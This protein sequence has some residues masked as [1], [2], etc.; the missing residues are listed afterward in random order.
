MRNFPDASPPGYGRVDA[1]GAI[2]NEVFHEA[3]VIPP[4]TPAAAAAL[5]NSK[6]ADAPVSY[7]FLW[8][9]PQHNV[10]QW[11]GV[12]QNA[13]LG[14]LGRNVGEVLGVF[15]RVD[16]P[17]KPGVTGY[18]SSVQVR[19]LRALEKL[20][21]GLWSPQWPA[22]LPPIDAALRDQGRAVFV[23]A[24][25]SECHGEIDRKDPLR[26]V[27]AKLV[28]VGTDDRMA[29]N[30]AR[31]KGDT[32]KLKGA[33]L[34]VVR[35]SVLAPETFGDQASAED[36]LSHAVIG[37]ILGSW[38]DA[39]E[40]ELTAIEYKRRRLLIQGSAAPA[41]PAGGTYKAR[42][43]NGIWATGPYLHNG[44]V[45]TLHHLLLPAKDRPG[46]FTVG[47]REFDPELIGFRTD[48]P[49]YPPFRARQADG[50]P[51]PGNSN[52][53]HEYGSALGAA[54]RKALLEYLKSL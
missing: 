42:P 2:V 26:R 16:I 8:D 1:F 4:G 28:A 32:G 49:N 25:C 19:N 33:F 44:S 3:A 6:P 15:G 54:D 17:A 14:A 5:V 46:T 53:G 40:D 27:V 24:R 22:G 50:T 29:G 36:I 52:E 11:N 37:T 45:P 10:V 12:V 38:K 31:R 35:T 39:P 23:K 21:E 13:G 30:F 18:Q 51:V 9:T 7:P 20:L 34:K 43:L 47:S 41:P 48:A